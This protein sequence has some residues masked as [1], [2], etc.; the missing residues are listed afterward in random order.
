MQTGLCPCHTTRSCIYHHE[1]STAPEPGT[2]PATPAHG[3]AM[4]FHF[5]ELLCSLTQALLT[6]FLCNQGRCNPKKINRGLPSLSQTTF[7]MFCPSQ[8]DFSTLVEQEAGAG[9]G[10][11]VLWCPQS[12]LSR[13]GRQGITQPGGLSLGRQS[14]TTRREQPMEAPQCFRSNVGMPKAPSLAA[15]AALA[16]PPDR[17]CAPQRGQGQVGVLLQG[18]QA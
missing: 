10:D 5:A 18:G 6:Q 9:T 3:G 7:A 14:L 1:S 4:H 16:S 2:I 12:R 8:H 13:E 11:A 15:H 17:H